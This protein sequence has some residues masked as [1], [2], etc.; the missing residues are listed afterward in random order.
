MSTKIEQD[1]FGKNLKEGGV[2]RKNEFTQING[3]TE[4]FHLINGHV[5]EELDAL[6]RKIIL[7]K[8]SIKSNKTNLKLPSPILMI[9]LI[10]GE[11]W[12][13]SVSGSGFKFAGK[14]GESQY[15]KD[16]QDNF[17]E[18]SKD[19]N[20]C[21]SC[22]IKLVPYYLASDKNH[23][24]DKSNLMNVREKNL[25]YWKRYKQGILLMLFDRI[26]KNIREVELNFKFL[27]TTKLNTDQYVL[28]Q[29]MKRWLAK[30]PKKQVQ[31]LKFIFL[32]KFNEALKNLQQFFKEYQ[33][34]EKYLKDT[35]SK[36]H[37]IIE[38]KDAHRNELVILC[39][40]AGYSQ[41]DWKQNV[42]DMWEM[43]LDVEFDILDILGIFGQ[44]CEDNLLEYI[45][46]YPDTLEKTRNH[47]FFA[48]DNFKES[49]LM[50]IEKGKIPIREPCEFCFFNFPIKIKLIGENKLS[51]WVYFEKIVLEDFIPKSHPEIFEFLS[52]LIMRRDLELFK[53]KYKEHMLENNLKLSQFNC[54][55][56]TLF[57]CAAY[58]NP[59]IEI[60][61]YIYEEDKNVLDI[62]D[63]YG[64]TAIHYAAQNSHRAFIQ[65]FIHLVEFDEFD[66]MNMSPF[67]LAITSRNEAI[68]EIFLNKDVDML[69]EEN[70]TNYN[71]FQLACLCAPFEL[72]KKIFSKM[73]N[74]KKF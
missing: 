68:I 56:R 10:S 19:F 3:K 38:K 16:Y 1:M 35:C 63:W 6:I 18:I 41:K 24:L 12:K 2:L 73:E 30:I 54:Q 62:K 36:W 28:I 31:F 69:E 40:Q 74:L 58:Y 61:K 67:H 9:Y 45:N 48:I 22:K 33:L 29:L 44:C 15:L 4:H 66:Q 49:N 72:I 64:R 11:K 8:K 47:F 71:A 26:L 27:L 42:N 70:L 5:P 39:N 14:E 53:V 23:L 34:D 17:N 57:H 13:I 55:G 43:L 52:R 50:K 25:D 60:A 21:I 7:A 51:K 65:Y 59:G 37:E 46:A 32:E 20:K